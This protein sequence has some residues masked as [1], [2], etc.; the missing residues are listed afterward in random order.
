[1]ARVTAGD[2]APTSTWNAKRRTG[3]VVRMRAMMIRPKP[4]IN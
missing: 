2:G 1:M 4:V 3:R